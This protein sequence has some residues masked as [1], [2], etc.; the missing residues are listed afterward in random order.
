MIVDSLAREIE[1]ICNRGRGPRFPEEGKDGSPRRI[2]EGA[3]LIRIV[4]DP[5]FDLC[6]AMAGRRSACKG[7][8][9]G[10]G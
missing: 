3:G 1:S 2:Q 9:E 8:R 10:G 4:D 7:R 5:E 6:F